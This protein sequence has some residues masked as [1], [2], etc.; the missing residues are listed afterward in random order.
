LGF[1]IS[2]APTTHGTGGTQTTISYGP[3]KADSAR[4]LA[5][6]LPG[7]SL[8]PDPTLG[9]TLEVVIGSS[10]TNTHPVTISSAPA[11]PAAAASSAPKPAVSAADT[12][13]AP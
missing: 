2:G 8:A 5:A 10:Y 11:T 7:S 9:R 4:T 6:A 13:C 12:T 1:T 3:T